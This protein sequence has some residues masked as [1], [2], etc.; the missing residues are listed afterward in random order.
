M[1]LKLKTQGFD[2][3][4]DPICPRCGKL[5]SLM[6]RGLNTELGASYEGQIFTCRECEL[7]FC[8]A[9]KPTESLT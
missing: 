3:D 2:A 1:S 6:R 9:R 4:G 8:V 7:K 5:K